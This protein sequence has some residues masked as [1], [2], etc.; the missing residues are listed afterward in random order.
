MGQRSF[1]RWTRDY[2]ATELFIKRD[3]LW[4]HSYLMQSDPEI[5]GARIWMVSINYGDLRGSSQTG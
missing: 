3:F 2:Y 1:N 4:R 5:S